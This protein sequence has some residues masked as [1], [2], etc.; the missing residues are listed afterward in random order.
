MPDERQTVRDPA[1]AHLVYRQE[2]IGTG[3]IELAPHKEPQYAKRCPSA[4][5]EFAR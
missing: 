4:Q 5:H 3:E 2:S 1:L